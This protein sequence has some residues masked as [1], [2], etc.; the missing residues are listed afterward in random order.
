MRRTLK[1]M[2]DAVGLLESARAGVELVK[3]T[4]RLSTSRWLILRTR[5][6]G[7]T[8][9]DAHAETMD[10][11]AK[12]AGMIYVCSLP[13]LAL[14]V[15]RVSPL[16][17]I[18]LLDPDYELEGLSRVGPANH[19]RLH[20]H[21]IS[22]PIP[23]YI[24]PGRDDV[25]RLLRFGEAWDARSPTLIHC[26]AGVSRSMAAAFIL[27]CQLNE[28]RELE[29]AFVLRRQAPHAMPNRRMVELADRLLNRGGGMIGALQA[30]PP[31]T[32]LTYTGLVSLP[33]KL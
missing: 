3:R 15:E 1:T 24:P 20:F 22:E 31:P 9:T 23:G 30:M 8:H 17:V 4:V 19:L 10:R 6:N 18:S 16:H 21:D 11:R 32:R 13:A 25:E 27:M 33:A 26:H 28:G 7:E 5:L 12:F 14:E 2:L 29:A